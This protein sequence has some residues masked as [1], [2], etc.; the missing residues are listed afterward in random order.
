[1]FFTFILNC[2]LTPFSNKSESSRELTILILSCIS[3]F[4]ITIV[5]VPDAKIF[6]LCIPASAADAGAVNPNGIKKRLVKV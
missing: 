5:V 4:D 6:F 2:V 1:M 3:S